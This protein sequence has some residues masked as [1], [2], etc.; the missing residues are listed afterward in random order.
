VVT[1]RFFAIQFTALIRPIWAYFDSAAL[2]DI[3]TH[4]SS[5]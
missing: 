3:S 1:I 2:V 4:D 5:C